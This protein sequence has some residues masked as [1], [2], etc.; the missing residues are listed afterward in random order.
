MGLTVIPQGLAYAVLAGLPTEYG[1]Y[2]SF[3]GVFVYCFLGTSKDITLGPTAIMSML[4]AAC[5]KRPDTWPM[6]YPDGPATESDPILAV[7]LTFLTG[8]I[9]LVLGILNLGFVVNFISHAIIV[10]FCS[11]ASIIISASQIKKLFGI[12]LKNREFFHMI[13]ELFENIINGNINWYDF[14]MGITCLIILKSLE[15]LKR[16][17]SDSNNLNPVGT[18]VYLAVL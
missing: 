2:S 3:M 8:I 17:Y 13:P 16:R 1:L 5:C 18:T 7:N 9:L 15:L 4:V 10:G 14:G 6:E 12:K 11:A